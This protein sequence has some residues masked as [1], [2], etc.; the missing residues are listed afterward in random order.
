MCS[1]IE[2]IQISKPIFSRTDPTVLKMQVLV[3]N[4]SL[5]S[6]LELASIATT[7]FASDQFFQMPVF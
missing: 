1:S 7:G 3:V 4:L 2:N 5:L 6:V